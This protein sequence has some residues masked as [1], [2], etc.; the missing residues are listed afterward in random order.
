MHSKSND[1]IIIVI[2]TLKHNIMLYKPSKRIIK[3][4]Q[5]LETNSEL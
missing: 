2:T 5:T 1:N 4:H 3:T